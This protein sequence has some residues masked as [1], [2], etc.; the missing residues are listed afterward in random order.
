VQV[1]APGWWRGHCS[2]VA[3]T[4]TRVVLVRRAQTCSTFHQASFPLRAIGHLTVHPAPPEGLRFRLTVGLDLEEFT[5]TG[6][7]SEFERALR[8]SLR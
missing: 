8:A 1:L 2:L 5:V 4:T 6:H 7:W 3:V